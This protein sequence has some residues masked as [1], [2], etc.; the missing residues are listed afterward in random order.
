MKRITLFVFGLFVV[1]SW[2]SYG[3]AM[4][5]YFLI[6]PSR[7][8][9]GA[10]EFVEYHNLLERA[11]LPVSVL[12]FL[13]ITLLN[14]FLLWKRPAGVSG[15]LLVISM[16]CLLIVWTSSIFIQIPMN[17][18]LGAGKNPALVQKVMDTNKVREVLETTQAVIVFV[19]LLQSLT[20]QTNKNQ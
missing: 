1:L 3:T 11:I 17:I 6:Y 2:F 4:M 19:L 16:V 15:I 13:V 10:N 20:F 18:E 8:I 12:P 9:V 7:A 5:D 14:A